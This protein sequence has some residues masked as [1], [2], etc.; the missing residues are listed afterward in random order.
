MIDHFSDES[1]D[2]KTSRQLNLRTRKRVKRPPII[3]PTGSD[4]DEDASNQ[5]SS[6]GSGPKFDDDEPEIP[7]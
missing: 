2:D 3:T 6:R 1:I 7:R 5:F 4:H